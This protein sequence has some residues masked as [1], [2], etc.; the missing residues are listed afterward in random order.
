MYTNGFTGQKFL[1]IIAVQAVDGRTVA[2]LTTHEF[3]EASEH[4]TLEGD[5]FEHAYAGRHDIFDDVFTG[6]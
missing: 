5:R 4:I 3:A 6:I 1:S 2:A